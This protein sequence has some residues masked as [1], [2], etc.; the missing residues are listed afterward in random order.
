[1]PLPD[2]PELA[3]RPATPDDAA[4]LQPLIEAVH[5]H[6]GSPEHYTVDDVADELGAPWLRL[7]RDAVVGLDDAGVARAFGLV[8][9]RPGDVTLLRVLTDGGVHPAV[10][11]RGIGRALLAWQLGQGRDLADRRRAEL[12]A[13]VPGRVM[14][15]IEDG[16]PGAGRLARRL[17]LTPIRYFTVMRRRLAGVLP[18]V[19]LPAG[20]RLVPWTADLDDAFREAHNDAFA[21]HWGFQ[22][23]TA[24]T[25]VQWESGHRNFRG[26]WSFAVLD[27]SQIAAYALSAAYDQDWPSLGFTE[28]WTGKLGVRRPWRGRGLAKALLA[29]SM[30]AFAEA[31]MESAGLDVDSENP[32]GAVALYEGL[33][34][35]VAHRTATWSLPV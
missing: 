3:W 15:T 30:Q 11:G 7:D 16:A 10:R 20:L 17:G 5:E 19:D 33:G 1:M 14:L 18:T 2:A 28:G 21:D 12:G 29:R 35:R 32:T 22:P 26:D 31:G 34:Y 23:W 9:V 24:E 4:L 13:D 25:W 8:Q 6:D 27:G